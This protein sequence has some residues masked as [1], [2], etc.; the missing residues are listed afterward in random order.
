[1]S[2]DI[3]IIMVCLR[4]D[5]PAV[6]LAH[7]MQV[8]FIMKGY[9]ETSNLMPKFWEAILLLYCSKENNLNF[10]IITRIC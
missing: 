7:R 6:K 2:N 5:L 8:D 9:L 1:M 4:L 3:E 10:F